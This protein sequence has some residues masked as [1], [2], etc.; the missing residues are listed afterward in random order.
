MKQCGRC[1][2]TKIEDDFYFDNKLSAIRGICKACDKEYAT[3]YY[4]KNVFDL[5]EKS[6]KDYKENKSKRLNYSKEWFDKNKDKLASYNK[7]YQ[8]SEIYV[9]QKKLSYLRLKM[10]EMKISFREFIERIESFLPENVSWDDYKK[11]WEIT[12]DGDKNILSNYKIKFY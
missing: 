2:E 1:G 10:K 11:T 4:K 6:R 5:R 9:K 3:D 8:S 12:V 7:K